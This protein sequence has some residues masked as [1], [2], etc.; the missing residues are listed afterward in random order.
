MPWK[1]CLHRQNIQKSDGLI[2]TAEANADAIL[3]LRRTISAPRDRV[4]DAWTSPELMRQWFCPD[5]SFSVAIAEVDLQIGG[6]YRIGMKDPNETV[7]IAKGVYR[8]IKKP[9]RLAFTWSWEHDSI[10]TLVTLTFTDLGDATELT[11]KHEY[12]PTVQHRDSH[13]Q[14]WNGC[15][16][17]LEKFLLHSIT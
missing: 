1:D 3:I 2:M 16:Q 8:E 10:D 15:L 6:T 5:D 12:L 11:L 14:G 9:E 4:F 7:R 13:A 17:H